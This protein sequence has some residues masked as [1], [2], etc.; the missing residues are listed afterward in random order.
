M[1]DIRLLQPHIHAGRDYPPDAVLTVDDGTAIWLRDHRIG[2]PAAPDFITH[3]APRDA[4]PD[5]TEDETP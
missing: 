5:T 2:V 1:P 3:P 4:E